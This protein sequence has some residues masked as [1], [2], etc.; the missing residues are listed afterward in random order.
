MALPCNYKQPTPGTNPFRG[1]HFMEDLPMNNTLARETNLFTIVT[2]PGTPSVV[3]LSI[4]L[5]PRS[6]Y[7]VCWNVEGPYGS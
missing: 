3:Y 4:D 2:N 1:N 6:G 5:K 7:C